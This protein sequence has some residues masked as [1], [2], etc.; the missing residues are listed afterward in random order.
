[1][2][3]ETRE[4]AQRALATHNYLREVSEREPDHEYNRAAWLAWHAAEYKPAYDSWSRAMDALTAAGY[5]GSRH[6]LQFRPWCEA[7]LI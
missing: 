5:P 3:D 4:A 6:P 2:S 7:V 1:M